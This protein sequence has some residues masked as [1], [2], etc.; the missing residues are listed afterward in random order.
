MKN[1]YLAG[2][3]SGFATGIISEL[4]NI[5]LVLLTSS[6]SLLSGIPSEF[7][8]PE[9]YLMLAVT[10]VSVVSG[11][12]LAILGL[13]FV[14]V[15]KHLPFKTTMRRSVLFFLIV[16]AFF[17]IIQVDISRMMD[18]VFGMLLT[19]VDGIV[20]GFLFIK[21]SGQKEKISL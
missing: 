4:L 12:F 18:F 8:S 9:I 16:G 1:V 3:V 14:F 19:V 17:G 15:K 21:L 20:F 2:L 6:S 10:L 13:A 7:F 5:V 11:A